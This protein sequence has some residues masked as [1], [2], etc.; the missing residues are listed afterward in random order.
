MNPS[1]ASS[2]RNESSSRTPEQQERL[3]AYRKAWFPPRDEDHFDF[4]LRIVGKWDEAQYQRMIVTARDL[5]VADAASGPELSWEGAFGS[6]ID[7]IVSLMS[8]PGFLAENDLGLTRDEYLRFITE[9]IQTLRALQR[10]YPA[11]G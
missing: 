8:H 3:A 5:L 6:V 1:Q 7:G 11:V 10:S 4:K 9:R 2:S